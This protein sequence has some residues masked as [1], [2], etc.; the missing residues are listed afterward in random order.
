MLAALVGNLGVAVMGRA[1]PAVNVFSIALGTVLVLGT[2][3]MLSSAGNFIGGITS[4]AV[5][6]A[7][8]LA[9]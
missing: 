3:V 9:P 4:T 1:A 2:V 5:D 6:A 8:I 7:H